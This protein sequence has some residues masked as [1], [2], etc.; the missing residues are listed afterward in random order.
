MFNAIELI[1]DSS[2]VLDCNGLLFYRP[3]SLV[4]W[5]SYQ[6]MFC[7]QK[8]TPWNHQNQPCHGYTTIITK[9]NDADPFHMIL[10][11]CVAQGLADFVLVYQVWPTACTT[12]RSGVYPKSDEPWLIVVSLLTCNPQRIERPLPMQF[13]RRVQHWPLLFIVVSFVRVASNV[14]WRPVSPTKIWSNSVLL[15]KNKHHSHPP[16][17]ETTLPYWLIVV[18]CVSILYMP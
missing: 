6:L 10:S 1:Y 7:Y 11:C 17:I 2:L 12:V 15:V 16:P 5:S 9:S 8:S 4:S 3:I 14:K 18:W 13:I